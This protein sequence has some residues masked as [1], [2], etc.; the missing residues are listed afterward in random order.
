MNNAANLDP[1]KNMNACEDF[2]NIVLHSHVV[3]A[4][5]FLESSNHY[6]K[7]EELAK[8]I[9]AQYVH[10]DPDSKVSTQDKVYLYGT[11]VLTLGLLWHIFVESIREGD[12]DRVI[13]CWKFL[14]LVFKAKNHSNYAKEAVIL[15]SQNYC[16]LSNWQASQQTWNRFVN[17]KGR[18]GCN[19]SCDLHLEHLNRRLKGMVSNLHSN[20]HKSAI[21]RAAKSIG[22]VHDLCQRFEEHSGIVPESDLHSKPSVSKD[23]DLVL[24]V[25]EEQRIFEEHPGRKHVSFSKIKPILQQSPTKIFTTWLADRICKYK[26]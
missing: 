2:L 24:Q 13:L 19:I 12:G 14:L 1:A 8:A 23:I 25:I 3:G 9:V 11:E 10:F 5:K 22:I 16:L 18:R 7:V 20:V 4:A 15:L 21:D 26:L 17:T 6:E